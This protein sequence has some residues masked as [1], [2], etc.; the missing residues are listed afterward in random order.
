MYLHHQLSK[1]FWLNEILK[2]HQS[3]PHQH[4]HPLSA[5]TPRRPLVGWG[6]FA[7]SGA[8]WGGGVT[9]SYFEWL[10]NLSH[11]GFGRLNKSFEQN[12][13]TRLVETLEELTG[14]KLNADDIQCIV[15]GS[16]DI[17][18]VR[19][20]LEETMINS[21]HTI[22]QQLKCNPVCS[23]LPSTAFLVAINKIAS[24]YF[25]MGIFP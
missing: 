5:P 21:Y 3:T 8:R 12:S 4:P 9:I 22:R 13:N 25:A 17:D 18:L 6:V 1:S 2:H 24:D 15:K 23:N 14:K 10:K 11:V 19:S 16:D 20:G 7:T